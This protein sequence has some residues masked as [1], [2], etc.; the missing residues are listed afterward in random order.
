MMEKSSKSPKTKKTPVTKSFPIVGIG[1]S[2]GGLEALESFFPNV[3]FDANIA[4]VVVQHLDPRQ[5]SIM[6]SLLQKYTRMKILE[7]QDGLKLESNCIY[8]NPPNKNMSILN[9]TLQFIEPTGRHELNLPIDFFFRALSQDQA[10]KAIGIILSGTGSDGTLGLRAIKG[11][12]GMAMVQDENQAKYNGMPRSAIDTG[13]VDYVLPVEQM[14][15]ELIKYLSFPGQEVH[16]SARSSQ[17]KFQNYLQKIFVL[18]RAQ[19]GHDF[20]HYKQNTIRRRIE[21]RL[22]VHQ[23][24]NLADYVRFLQ[25]TPTE[26]EIL[27]KDLLITVT[28]FFRDAEA[29]ELLKEKGLAKMLDNLPSDTTF[30]IWIPGCATG[31]EAYSLAM[32]LTEALE[33]SKKHLNIQIF[34]TDIDEAA[35]ER[36]R[37]AVYPESI[38]ADV[39]EERLQRFFIKEDNSYKIRKSIRELVIFSVQN[40]VK[41]P[42]FSRLHLV[43]CR[44][45]LIYMDQVLQKKILPLFHYTLNPDGILFLGSSESIGEFTDLFATIDSKWKIFQRQSAGSEKFVEY[46]RI[47]FRDPNGLSGKPEERASKGAP[48]IR[49]IAERVILDKFS[50]PSLLINEKYD[51][52]FFNGDTSQFL[53]P[54]VGEASFNLLKMVRED[55]RFVLNSALNRAMKQHTAVTSDMVRVKLDNTWLTF[56]LRIQPLS[57]VESHPDL[58]MVVFQNKK[59][60]KPIRKSAAEPEKQFIDQRIKG[61]EQEL[62]STKEYLQTTIEELETTNEELKSSNEELQSTNEELQSTNEELETSKEELQSTNEELIT[63]NSEL[64][65]KV[66]ELSRANNDINNLLASTDIGTIFLDDSLRI[67]RFTPAMTKIFNLILSDIDRPI[68]DITSNI[69]YQNLAGDAKKVLITL[70]PKEIIVQ[71]K[72]MQYFSARIVPY[73]TLENRIDGVVITFVDITKTRQAEMAERLAAV[74]RDSNDAITVQ[75][76]DGRITAWNKGAEKMYGYSEPEALK[77]SIFDLIPESKKQETANLFDAAKSGKMIQ[78]FETDRLRKDGQILCVWITVTWLT[79]VAGRVNSIA[80]TERDLTEFRQVKADYENQIE[81]LRRQLRAQKAK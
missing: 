76:L 72:E 56:D 8:L 34:A 18:I 62:Q 27:F 35:I 42:P 3:P 36:A 26:L 41:D 32:L 66:D 6:G 52:L 46:P 81:N 61:L 53:T 44:N 39:S 33:N 30:R 28:N 45:L 49:K 79:D 64:Q 10:E 40:L 57:E 75:N 71:T 24:N 9:G 4:F 11:A 7:A 63:V 12:G 73:R 17:Q 1:A 70:I 47:F 38:I 20:S 21:R 74:V 60:H 43:S 29:F 51:I 5:K 50:F 77:M 68:S 58:F 15:P 13:L 19:T 69:E 25:Q 54:P 80:T 78:S 59:V 22:A 65:N 67:K 2:A 23:I 37:M 31:E 14:G 48:D 16:E 55:F